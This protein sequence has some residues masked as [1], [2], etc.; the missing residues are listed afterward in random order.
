MHEVYTKCFIG[1][2]LTAHDGFP[3]T[4]AELG[5][6]GRKC[7]WNGASPNA[8]PWQSVDDLVAAIRTESESIGQENAELAARVRGYLD[9][10]RDWL[11]P[12]YYRGKV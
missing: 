10:G 3:N 1:L 12:E 2:R 11:S 9:I 5:L 8:I 7:A 4:V 6:M